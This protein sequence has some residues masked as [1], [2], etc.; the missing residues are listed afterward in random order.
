M[1]IK[2]V[3]ERT[4]LTQKTIRFYESAG[5]ISPKTDDL[6][7]R[8]FRDYSEA[9]IV[10]LKEIAVLRKARFSIEEIKQLQEN[11][12]G[13]QEIFSRYYS[14]IQAE[15]TELDQLLRVLDS[16]AEHT[17]ESK[18]ELV[19]EI[20][21]A[22]EELSLPFVDIHPQFR[23]MDALEEKLNLRDDR[24]QRKNRRLMQTAAMAQGASL[25]QCHTKPGVRDLS[26]PGASVIM[27]M[28]LLDDDQNDD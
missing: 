8:S 21:D 7:G 27:T 19:H 16:I 3:S 28:R 13:V 25:A 17:F 24:K 6:N 4:G 26:M 1:K 12:Q 5:L 20:L 11:P 18:S 23:Y 15:K 9:D 2:E 22:T 14:R 10:R